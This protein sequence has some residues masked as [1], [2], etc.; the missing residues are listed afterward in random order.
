MPYLLLKVVLMQISQMKK[1]LI[2]IFLVA[3]AV[4][5]LGLQT[6][7]QTI[8][9]DSSA[10]IS[11]SEIISK[12]EKTWQGQY[13]DYFQRDFETKGM[14]GEEI[15][16]DLLK[17]QQKTQKNPAVIWAR[18]NPDNLELFLIMPGKDAITRKIPKANAI[19]LSKTIQFFLAEISRPSLSKR[20]LTLGKK[21]HDW[22]IFP[23]EADLKANKIDT[24]IFCLG[25]GLRSLPLPALYDGKQF[26]VEK[27]S[28][29][30]IPGFN[31][32]TI[33]QGDLG[34]AQVLAMGASQ[35]KEQPA[36]PGVAI[37]L[38]TIIETP[39]KGQSVLNQGFTVDNLKSL[40]QQE[41]FKI[42]HLATH[43]DFQPG[44]PTQ[45]YIQFGDRKL[46]LAELPDLNL[47]DPS[48]ELLVLS[49]CQTAL[50]DKDVELGFSGL[51]LQGGVKSVL[52]SFWSVSDA[53]TF[54]LMSEFYQRLKSTLN[55]A[56]ALQQTQIAMI[57]GEVYLRG[58][59]LVSSRG[60]VVMPDI[61]VN[62]N[63]KDL[64]HPFYWAGFS[65]IGS[66]W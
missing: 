62:N 37:E 57:R 38:K 11:P 21:L 45:S 33:A 32:T 35:F 10:S 23:I 14:T 24:L 43:A 50:G 61:L 7:S 53:G 26:L 56:E 30:R 2:L 25:G 12:I 20:Y 15:S 41:P 47:N 36:L 29:T 54:A 65:L 42:I 3:I 49:A 18:S 59:E 6:D 31:L 4:I 9:A 64:S 51:A 63:K 55:K 1:Y 66:P 34:N 39:W 13:S 5:G 48:V 22:L 19:E 44:D 46:T 60:N 27:Y 58:G 52:A 17:I 16:R 8:P 28:L 40:R